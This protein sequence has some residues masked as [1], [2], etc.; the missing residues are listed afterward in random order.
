MSV[1]CRLADSGNRAS[2]CAPSRIADGQSGQKPVVRICG[3]QTVICDRYRMR[4]FGENRTRLAKQLDVPA[5]IQ[6]SRFAKSAECPIEVAP[7]DIG[8]NPPIVFRLQG[9]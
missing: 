5:D 8:A 6:A 7:P 3:T 9:F 2:A 4:N 1:V